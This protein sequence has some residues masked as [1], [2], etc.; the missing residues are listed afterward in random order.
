MLVNI[1][2]DCETIEFIIV[3][4]KRAAS[5]HALWLLMVSVNVRQLKRIN[6]L[7]IDSGNVMNAFHGINI[8]TL[9]SATAIQACLIITHCCKIIY[10]IVTCT[11]IVIVLDIIIDPLPILLL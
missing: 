9:K 4:S 3:L 7:S 5:V 2:V 11:M 6:D 8:T 1:C 10:N